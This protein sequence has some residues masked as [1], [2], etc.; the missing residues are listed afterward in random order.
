[1]RSKQ[2]FLYYQQLIRKTFS[3]KKIYNDDTVEIQKMT[4]LN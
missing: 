3:I 4:G 1:M 2:R